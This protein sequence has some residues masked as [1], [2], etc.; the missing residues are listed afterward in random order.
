MVMVGHANDGMVYACVQPTGLLASF[1]SK[2]K[3][4]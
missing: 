4:R 1:Q 2:K 3:T